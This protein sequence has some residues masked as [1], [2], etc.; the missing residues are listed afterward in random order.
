MRSYTQDFSGSGQGPVDGS[1]IKNTLFH[2]EAD[3]S[4]TGYIPPLGVREQK[5]GLDWSY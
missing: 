2:C 5:L 3:V 1:Y 4:E